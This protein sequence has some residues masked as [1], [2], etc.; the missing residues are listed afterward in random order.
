MDEL[1]IALVDEA[2]TLDRRTKE[3]KKRLDEIKAQLTAQATTVMDN[4]NLKYYQIFG[5]TGRFNVS[6][7]EKFE[8]DR[9][10][11]LKAILGDL[12]EGKISKKEDV[13]YDAEPKFKA[14]LIALFRE[15]YSQAISISTVLEKLGLE[16]AAIKAVAKKLKGDYI[17]DKKLLESVGAQGDLEEELDAIRQYKNWEAVNR[18]FA[19]LSDEQLT[20]IKRAI[21]VEDGIAVGL[22]YEK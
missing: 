22:D 10:S 16:K 12:A 15:D 17:S 1:L 8:I 3:D 19:G 21:F 6:F 13:K 11:V 7:K 2:I 4:R 20:E 9:Y 14:A 5:H 18:F